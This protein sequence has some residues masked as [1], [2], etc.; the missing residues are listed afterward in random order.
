MPIW[1]AV[2]HQLGRLLQERNLADRE[3]RL[4]PQGGR[5][6]LRVSSIGKCRRLLAYELHR[7]AILLG[8]P[9]T[10]PEGPLGQGVLEA[11]APWSAH[12]LFT[13][14]LGNAMH[15]MT[16]QWLREAG[17]LDAES[18]LDDEGHLQW[19]GDA[20]V[21]VRDDELGILGHCDGIS[22]PLR[23]TPE[24]G[25]EP[26]PTCAE[27]K[28]AR[29]GQC[30]R[31]LLEIKSITARTKPK[32]RAYGQGTAWESI[33]VDE[34]RRV[35][36]GVIANFSGQYDRLAG[37]KEEHRAQGTM[38]TYLL[39]KLHQ[40][41]LPRQLFLYEAKDLDPSSYE[42]P[43]CPTNLPVKAIVEETDPKLQA[44]LVEK[45]RQIWSAVEAGSLPPPD[46][47][48]SEDKPAFECLYCDYHA[49]CAP[50]RFGA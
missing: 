15:D 3:A 37:P 31:Y 23:E 6:Y 4:A 48:L 29:C 16:Q 41:P 10:D 28:V 2:A 24:G 44:A 1:P 42:D 40:I 17:W 7:E 20:E 18:Y 13:T 9:R 38:Y 50:E 49:L 46:H 12:G 25:L 22:R 27:S 26:C 45:C 47:D 39:Q 36:G 30:C 21:R 5:P 35:G 11:V 43:D 32:F 8:C 34:R 19:R 33:G 14:S